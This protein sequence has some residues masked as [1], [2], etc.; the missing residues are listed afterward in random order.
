MKNKFFVAMLVLAAT[1]L[2][3]KQSAPVISGDYLEVRSCDV[4]TGPCFANSEYGLAGKEGILVWSIRE[5][6]WKGVSLNGLSVIAVVRADGTLTDLRYEPRQGKAVLIVDEYAT[7][8]QKEALKDFALSMTGKLI[9]EVADVKPARMEVAMRTCTK[10]GCASVKAG[11]LVEVTTR[12]LGSHDH[13]CGNESAYY[14]PL[15]EVIGAY[16]AYTEHAAFKGQ[17]L[18]ETWE[19]TGGRSAFL[20]TFAK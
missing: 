11:N 18:N 4:Y 13:I 12:C 8:S 7:A 9:T 6:S 17:G 14:P 5:G 10:A 16:P 2:T 19:A 1:G 3:A 20:A 15:T